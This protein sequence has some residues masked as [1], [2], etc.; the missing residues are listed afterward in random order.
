MYKKIILMKLTFVLIGIL[1]DFKKEKGTKINYLKIDC[2]HKLI[3]KNPNKI[4]S[5]L[6][7]SF[8]YHHSL[9]V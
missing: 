9:W 3:F 5:I 8:H 6:S 4:K 2:L 7:H 1:M